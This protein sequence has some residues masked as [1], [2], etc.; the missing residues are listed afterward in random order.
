MAKRDVL[1]DALSTEARPPWLPSNVDAVEYDKQMRDF[2]GQHQRLPPRDI[3][4]IG[5]DNLVG[6]C[7]LCPS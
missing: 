3:E 6:V 2:L 4:K 1:H 5:V 7:A